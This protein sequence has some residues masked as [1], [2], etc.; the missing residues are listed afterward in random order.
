MTVYVLY[1]IYV[2]HLAFSICMRHSDFYSCTH[3]SLSIS[4]ITK[5]QI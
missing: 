1:V 4:N 3:D 2:V 5:E